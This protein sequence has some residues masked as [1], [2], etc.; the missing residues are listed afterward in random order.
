MTNGDPASPGSPFFFLAT[1]SRVQPHGR[2]RIAAHACLLC[3]PTHCAVAALIYLHDRGGTEFAGN[4][5]HKIRIKRMAYSMTSATKRFPPV[6]WL[7]NM[8]ETGKEAA[9][10]RNRYLT[11]L[12]LLERM[13]DR[14]LADINISRLQ[15]RDV[16]YE[17]AF[18]TQR[19]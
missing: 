2:G 15:I 4:L 1:A 9:Q 11:T 18:G 17:A 8:L 19:P 7:A 6:A 13:T 5:R 3:A 12:R 14:E 10:R 16:A